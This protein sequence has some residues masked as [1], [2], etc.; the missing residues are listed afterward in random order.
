MGL[1]S[2]AVAQN[3]T[4][5]LKGRTVDENGEPLPGV[6]VITSSPALIGT[7]SFISGSQ[8]NYRF[9]SLAPGTYTLIWELAGFKKA[10]LDGI[11]ISVGRATTMNVT[12]ELSAI[13]EE[14]TV[15][16]IAP[17]L[18]MTHTKVAT[19]FTRD[20]IENIPMPRSMEGMAHAAPGV[21]GSDSNGMGWEVSSHG[22]EMAQTIYAFDGLNTSDPSTMAPLTSVTGIDAWEEVEI[23]TGAHPADI[24][25]SGGPYINVITK[26]GGNKLHGR[27]AAYLVTAAM[28]DSNFTQD[29]LDTFGLGSP[30]GAKY[31]HD[32]NFVLGGPVIKDKLWF[33]TSGR[34]TRMARASAGFPL[35]MKQKREKIYGKLTFQATENIKL[36]GS[37]NYVYTRLGPYGGSKYRPLEATLQLHEPQLIYNALLNWTLSQNAYAQVSFLRVFNT[38]WQGQQDEATHQNRDH[39]TG[40]TTGG[41]ET[42]SERHRGKWLFSPSVTFFLDNTLGGDHEV[43]IGGE[44][45]FDPIRSDNFMNEPISTNTWDGSPYEFD[46]VGR[47]RAWGFPVEAG[48]AGRSKQSIRTYS[49]YIQDNWTIKNRVTVALGLRYQDS[50]GY[51]PAQ[52]SAQIDEWLFL[53]PVFFATKDY[54]EYKNIMNFKTL[55]PRIGL[56]YDITGDGK[57]VAKASFSRYMDNMRGAWFSNAN[58]NGYNYQDYEW[59]DDNMLRGVIFYE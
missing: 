46:N 14:V 4:G 22:S 33:F 34:A 39:L 23:V 45:E 59:I 40:M 16:A 50:H 48:E 41:W 3:R 7:K 35:D 55:S 43:K 25:S 56:T 36:T 27:L 32:L 53:D 19:T 9:P 15:T 51:L 28:V 8:G 52:T 49:A 10:T 20:L 6:L 24:G 26:S 13:E 30:S 2:A 17:V 5:S 54:P 57:T 37:W 29:Q 11:I 47:F 18:D 21:L 58:A 31:N 38:P 12:L 44:Y 1:I 42:T